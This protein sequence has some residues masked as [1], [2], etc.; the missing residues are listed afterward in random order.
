MA[1][2]LADL[3]VEP[4]DLWAIDDDWAPSPEGTTS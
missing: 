1:E 3:R 2:L 4:G